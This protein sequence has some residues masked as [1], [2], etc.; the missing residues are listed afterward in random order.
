[1]D[2]ATAQGRA[3]TL[4]NFDFLVDPPEGAERSV[5]ST[6]A[7]RLCHRTTNIG[8]SPLASPW[9]PAA[10]SPNPASPAA[11][12]PDLLRDPRGPRCHPGQRPHPP[13]STYAGQTAATTRHRRSL[14][15]PVGAPVSFARGWALIDGTFEGKKFRFVT[16][17]LEVEGY[18]ATQEAQ[19]REFLAGP[20]RAPGGGDRYGRLQLGRRP[21]H[22]RRTHGHLRRPDEA[23]VRRRLGS[24]PR[25]T[26]P[27]LL[28]ELEPEQPGLTAEHAHRPGPP[29]RPGARAGGPRRRRHALPGGR[30]AVGLGS[31]GVVATVRLH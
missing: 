16:T 8:P 22:D 24:Q 25:R 18:R 2:R 1:M 20:A 17:H 13:R 6:T 30:A 3:A 7:S 9:Q 15:P 29:A 5:G 31:A 26:R 10:P 19:A 11:W 4:P 23:L 27:D 14:T 21:G 12:L 28:P